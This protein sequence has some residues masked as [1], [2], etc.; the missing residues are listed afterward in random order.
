M[1]QKSTRIA[2][3]DA[4]VFD[5]SGRILLQL[6]SD[7]HRWG[8]PG[9]AIEVGETFEQAV[10]RETKEETNLEVAVNRLIGV[11]SDPA[12]TTTR[13]P[14]GD[15]VHYVSIVFECRVLGGNLAHNDESTDLRW[16]SQHELPP[17]VMKDHVPRIMDAFA[18][19]P[20]AVFR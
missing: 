20:E 3:A 9:G 2:G 15:L 17:D 5:N 1:S 12:F 6:R 4:A 8:L 18:R 16:F 7:F 19:L 10:V 14:G 13:Y 11:Y